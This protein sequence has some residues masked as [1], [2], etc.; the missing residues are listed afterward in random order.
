MK[1]L[2]I[3]YFPLVLVFSLYGC[4]DNNRDVMY[5]KPDLRK[6]SYFD[7]L[8]GEPDTTSETRYE[9]K[10]EGY[11]YPADE[12]GDLTPAGKIR[13]QNREMEASN[14]GGGGC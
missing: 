9:I 4:F 14:Q 13:K 1:K 5:I 3:L 6:I 11:W 2:L 12:N 7:R 8:T 10:I